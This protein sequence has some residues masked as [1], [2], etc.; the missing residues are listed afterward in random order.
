MY[1]F[2]KFFKNKTNSVLK[3]IFIIY[4]KNYKLNKLK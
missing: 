2:G 3:V 4:D 1:K